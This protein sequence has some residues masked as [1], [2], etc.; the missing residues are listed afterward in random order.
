MLLWVS[1]CFKS[2]NYFRAPLHLH[3]K[4]MSSLVY[5]AGY[6]NMALYDVM[7]NNGL[8]DNDYET[9]IFPTLKKLSDKFFID[10]SD[11]Y[12]FNSSILT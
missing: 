5:S 10:N 1:F 11:K 3:L 8:T 12:N 7:D 9:K 4:Y 6:Y 2:N